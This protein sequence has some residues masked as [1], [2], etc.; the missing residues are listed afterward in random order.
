[1]VLES[2]SGCPRSFEWDYIKVWLMKVA[3]GKSPK[4]KRIKHL[5]AA[6]IYC[7]W[8]ERNARIFQGSLEFSGSL[9]RGILQM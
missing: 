6:T 5:F 8:S 4:A 7:I 2:E 9:V 3:K 1:G